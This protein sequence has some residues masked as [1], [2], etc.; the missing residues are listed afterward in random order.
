MQATQRTAHWTVLLG[1][2]V[3]VWAPGVGAQ[4]ITGVSAKTWV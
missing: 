1:M 3:L 2:L 4:D